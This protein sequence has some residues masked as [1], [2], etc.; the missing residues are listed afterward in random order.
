[1]SLPRL[2]IIIPVRNEIAN[3]PCLFD[4]LSH[5]RLPAQL[6]ILC[7]DDASTDGSTAWLRERAEYDDRISLIHLARRHGKEAALDHAIQV[8][9]GDA[10][11]CMDA[12]LQDPPEL[13]AAMLA[14]WERGTQ[15]VIAHRAH[16]NDPLLRRLAAWTFYRTAGL[17]G[18][19]IVPDTG[20]YRLID[21]RVVRVFRAL[22][23]PKRHLRFITQWRGYE[24]AVVPYPR[25]AR[26]AGTSR[27]STSD[28]LKLG[29]ALLRQA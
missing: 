15:I 18:L 17:C 26:Q 28:L 29:W 14:H 6:Q 24:E 22:P 20:D 8:S 13:L 12:D 3:L 16:R 21:R 11:V 19:R 1:M 23:R 5:L 2:D 9:T 27:Y 7:I 25:P 4:R 10:L